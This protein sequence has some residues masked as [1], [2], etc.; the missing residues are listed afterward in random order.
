MIDLGTI[1]E[2]TLGV[3]AGQIDEA[4]EDPRLFA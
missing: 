4:P 1:S 3:P 2:E